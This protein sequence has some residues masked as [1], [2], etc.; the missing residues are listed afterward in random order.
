[1]LLRARLKAT[2]D[3]A[4]DVPDSTKFDKELAAAVKVFQMRHGLNADGVVGDNTKAEMNIPASIRVAQIKLNMQRWAD[5][6]PTLGHRY[7]MVNIPEYQLHVIDNDKQVLTMKVVVGRPTRQTPELNSRITRIVFNPKWNVPSMIAKNDIIPKVIENPNYL[8]TNNIRIFNSDQENSY[9]VNR[10]DVD[11]EDARENGF[12][13]RFRQDAGVKNALG[14]V[15][16]EFANTHDVYLHDTPAKGLFNADR[17]DFSSG[18]I[19]LEKPFA[20]VDYLVQNDERINNEKIND[21]L[22]SRVTT[23]FRVDHALPIVITY[24]TAWVDEQGLVHFTDDVYGRDGLIPEQYTGEDD[25]L[26][27]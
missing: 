24:L 9:E 16:F 11:W 12:N 8:T 23:Y 2:H 19:R 27:E 15:K 1:M 10:E 20:L 14:E 26:P 5:L 6:A 21:T 22:A 25:K 13:Y 3:L 4:A 7:L 17:R 18:C